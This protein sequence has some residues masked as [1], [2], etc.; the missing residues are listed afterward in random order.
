MVEINVAEIGA[1]NWSAWFDD[2]TSYSGASKEQAIGNLIAGY[3]AAHGICVVDVPRSGLQGSMFGNFDPKSGR[4]T[5][6]DRREIRE[7]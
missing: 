5:E 2:G 3:G 4:A 7:L 6:L 1:C